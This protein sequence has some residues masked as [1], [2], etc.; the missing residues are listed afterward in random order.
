MIENN[1]RVY[2]YNMGIN[3]REIR[4]LFNKTFSDVKDSAA[5]IEVKDNRNPGNF[6]EVNNMLCV[7]L[8]YAKEE[9]LNMTIYDTELEQREVIEERLNV[10]FTQGSITF[11]SIFISKEG[12]KYPVEINSHL[13]NINGKKIILGIMKD[14]SIKKELHETEER[15]R[16]LVELLPDAIHVKQNGNIVFTNEAGAKLYGVKNRKELIGR[17]DLEFTHTDYKSL[18]IERGN[19]IRNQKKRL[20]AVEQKCVREDGQIIDVEVAST[21]I[22]FNGEGAILSVLRD[23]TERK[24]WEN[25][26]EKAL[27]E[28]KK[29]L[30]NA[31]ELHEQKTEFFSNISHE[32]K[33]PLNVILGSIQLL[34][35]FCKR[36]K[37]KAPDDH[38]DLYR[39]IGIMKQNCYRLLRLINNLIDMNKADS[40]FL[41][42][43]FCNHD[44][45]CIIE[46]ITLSV[47]EF[48]RNKGLTLIFDTEIEEKIIRCDVDKIERIMLNL[49]SNSI[50]YTEPGGQVCVNIIDKKD[51]III[52]VKDTGIGIPKDKL[53]VVFERFEQLDASLRRKKEGSGI[54]LSLVKSFVEIH[55]GRIWAES[56]CG[57]GTQFFIELPSKKLPDIDL[58]CSYDDYSTNLVERINIEF[59]DIY[60]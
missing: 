51:K 13:F 50:K 40:K 54:G 41:E 33:T 27:E 25:R 3:L 53:E 21:F 9:L 14:I 34:E 46:D 39:Y 48:A 18:S 6:L 8:G 10:L 32:F 23:I 56:E 16:K 11:E 57:V 37:D 30:K 4:S 59:S 7:K 52:N 29:L 55:D 28:N 44:I 60:S 43:R 1:L 38:I 2:N 17:D 47:A 49:L 58:N 42:A 35:S 12:K 24:E 22:T 20:A 19:N 26:L 36:D 45:I 15:Y 5:L 31:V